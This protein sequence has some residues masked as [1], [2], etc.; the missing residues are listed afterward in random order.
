MAALRLSDKP[1]D[2]ILFQWSVLNSDAINMHLQL[3]LHIM[4][5]LEVFNALDASTIF[6]INGIV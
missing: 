5:L 4:S 6:R 1:M 3:H 2:G